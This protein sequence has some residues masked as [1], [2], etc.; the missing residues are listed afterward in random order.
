MITADDLLPT[1]KKLSASFIEEIGGT[2]TAQNSFIFIYLNNAL[3]K[4]AKIAYVMKISDPLTVS[5][6][7]FVTFKSGTQDISS[8]YA[9]L[10]II[11]PSGSETA[12]RTSFVDTK[13]GWWRESSNTQIHVRGMVGDYT[14]HYLTYPAQVVQT[15][16]AIEFPDAGSM[17]LA[18]YTV[19]L[20]VESLPN[21]KSLSV[22]FYTLA[23]QHLKI[24]TQANIDARG[25]SSG[26][27]I[28]SLNDVDMAFGGG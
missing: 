13:I 11:N 14:L 15:S 22:H 26:G 17:G 8:L 9:P 25:H 1:I 20:I 6:D 23:Q 18:Y 5:L 24:A 7:G 10:R 4:L 12:K 19:A 16:S 2:D 27:F 21:S 3:R 28:P